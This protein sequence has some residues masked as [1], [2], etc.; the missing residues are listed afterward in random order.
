MDKILVLD[1]ERSLCELLKVVFQKEGYEVLTTPSAKKAIEIAQSDD[2]D[3]VVSD[4]KLPEMNGLEVLKRLRKIKPELPVLMITAYGTIKE[5]VEAL[6]IGAYDYIIKPFDVEELKVIVA[7]ALETKRLQ[8]ENVR[9]RKEL[10]D[11]YSLESMIGKSKKMQEIYSLIEKIAPTETTVLIQGESGTGKEMAARA[12]HYLSLRREKPFVTINCGALPESLLE[13]ELFGHVKGAFTDAV[14]DK[15]GMFEVADKGTLFLD[16][17]GEM[18]PITQVKLL[19]T[20]QERKIRRVGGTEEIPI[21]V[22]IISATNQD[23]KKK[24]KEGFFRED[25]YYRLNVLSLEMP[26]LRERKEDI[27]LLVNH[28][29]QKYCQKLGR[30]MKRVAPEVY[31]I[32]ESYPWPGNI[33]ELENV[34]ERVVAIEERETITTSCLPKELL[35]PEKREIDL[36]IKPGFKLNETIEAITR[37]YVQKALEMSRG[38]LKEAAELLG[39]NY[40]SIR[41]LVDKFDLKAEREEGY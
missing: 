10:K 8:D 19:R 28:F 22:R 3:V 15:K 21:D 40:R 27:P 17:V 38:K 29:L 5:A 2:I 13:S 23:L 36:E 18:S 26:P 16:E 41:Y 14:T 24:I 34:I 7:K 9:L 12:I 11:K 1:D 37:D 20:L 30:G 6:K 31:N 4:I 25:L 39:V 35:Q 33:R 32:F